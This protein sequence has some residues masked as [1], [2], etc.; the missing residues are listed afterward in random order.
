MT[1]AK[2]SPALSR[3]AGPGGL[4]TQ[5][6]IMLVAAQLRVT[7]DMCLGDGTSGEATDMVV[8]LDLTTGRPILPATSQT[9]A[10][11][12]VMARAADVSEADLDALFGT[13][14]SP[15]RFRPYDAVADTPLPATGVRDGI[16]IDPA[17]GTVLRGHLFSTEVL[18]AGTTFPLVWEV[19]LPP[20]RDRAADL[21]ALAA[22]A[23]SI[24]SGGRI[25]FGRRT[26]IGFG[27]VTAH[28]WRAR[29][30][31]LS[32]GSDDV[33]A[34]HTPTLADRPLLADSRPGHPSAAEALNTAA[35]EGFP[36]IVPREAMPRNGLTVTVT[37]A[38]EEQ[39]A[40][41]WVPAP[42]L[43]AGVHTGLDNTSAHL[44][45]PCCG[46]DGS[47]SLQPL[48][49]GSTTLSLIRRTAS[50]ALAWITAERGDADQAA[51][52]LRDLFGSHP[53]E[54]IVSAARLRVDEGAFSESSDVTMSSVAINALAHTTVT[55]A[56][57][58]RTALFGGARTVTID[59]IDPVDV[60]I[61]VLRLALG[62]LVD[63]VAPPSGAGTATGDGRRRA[64]AVTVHYQ[65]GRATGQ[66]W[67]TWD[68][69]A[70]DPFVAN[71]HDELLDR[72]GAR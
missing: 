26:H 8:A 51:H 32:T 22:T 68:D 10:L 63:G 49:S 54:R 19:H 5:R 11:R 64:T 45:R 39:H 58:Q 15:S 70:G 3:F 67:E 2:P 37:L 25:R 1:A 16:A 60:D 30:F 48:D 65:S 62:D 21:L 35:P 31:D 40:G 61:A 17:T 66:T 42:L 41:Q 44:R 33:R 34:W 50:R 27:A 14:G 12:A 9:G 43:V 28:T 7:S 53:A 13:P 59:V 38:N 4:I 46:P 72:L 24:L 52:L 69:F 36:A 47:V 18:S 29:F 23:G 55:G 56:L 6:N 57:T 20:D 71:C